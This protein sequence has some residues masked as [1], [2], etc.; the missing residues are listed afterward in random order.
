MARWAEETWWHKREE[1]R[2]KGW[3]EERKRRG[4][5]KRGDEAMKG[6]H[7]MRRYKTEGEMMFDSFYHFTLSSSHRSCLLS[8]RMNQMWQT[9]EENMLSVVPCSPVQGK[10]IYSHLSRRLHLNS[11]EEAALRL[12][13]L[14]SGSLSPPQS[15]RSNVIPDQDRC[16]CSG[17]SGICSDSK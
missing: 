11:Q 13:T 9:S 7:K 5:S 16:Y 15:W 6:E 4:R 14:W 10:N 17:S 1:K 8:H 12:Q 2:A 3:Q